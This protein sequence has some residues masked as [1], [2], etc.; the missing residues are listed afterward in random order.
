MKTIVTLA[1]A[2]LIAASSGAA[3][4]IASA[5]PY[6]DYGRGD[7]C[8]HERQAAATRGSVVG[9]ILGGVF[10]ASVAGRHDRAAGAI[11]GGSVGA[12][13][14]HAIGGHSVACEEYPRRISWHRDNCH[15]VREFYDGADHEFEVCRDTDGVWRPSGRS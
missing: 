2:A 15:W 1:G 5:Q 3:P 11:I 9:A 8:H 4:T 7:I 10:G 13:A 14:G 6:P 12:V